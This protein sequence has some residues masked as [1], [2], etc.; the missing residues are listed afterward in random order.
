[1]ST[2]RSIAAFPIAPPPGLLLPGLLLPGL[3]L[4]EPLLLELLLPVTELLQELLP[5]VA[6]LRPIHSMTVQVAAIQAAAGLA[7]SLSIVREQAAQRASTS[8]QQAASVATL[9]E[10]AETSAVAADEF[11]A[12]QGPNP[13]R[14]RPLT[15]YP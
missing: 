14:L 4:P 3:L 1:V 10:G 8:R 9:G 13:S 6:A 11:Q 12:C 15:P 5:P 7:V 2:S